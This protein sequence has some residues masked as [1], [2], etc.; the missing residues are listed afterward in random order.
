MTRRANPDHRQATIAATACPLEGTAGPPREP[1]TLWYRQPARE[2]LEALPIGNGSLGGMVYGGVNSEIVQ[3][4]EESLWTGCPIPRDRENGPAVLREARKLLFEKKYGAAQALIQEQF[5]GRRIERGL[6]TYQTLGDLELQFPVR[7]AVED[8]RREL[9]LTTGITSVRYRFGQAVYTREVFC[10]AADGVLV[11][12]LS[13]DRPGMIEFQASLSRD[14]DARIRTSDFHAISLRGQAHALREFVEEHAE[15]S[16]LQGVRYAAR[17][18][19]IPDGGTTN[20]EG[21]CLH[22]KGAD[23]V[24]L[25][26]AGATSYRGGDPDAASELAVARALL[27]P[28]ELLRDDHVAEYRSWFARVELNLGG[29][30]GTR[31]PTDERLER[32]A[33]G[34]TDPQLAALYFQF[35]RY[36]LISSSRPEGLPANLQGIWADGFEPPWNADYHININI[37]MNYWPAEVCNLSECHAPFL[38]FIDALRP[39]GRETARKVFGCRG[40]VAGHTTDVWLHGSIIGR[41][42]YGMWPMGAAWSACHYW[43]HYLFTE[44][45]DFLAEQGY[46][47][48]REAAEFLLDWLVEDPATG[49]LVSGPSTSPENRFQTR[50]GEVANL[51]MGPAMDHQIIRD[52]FQACIQAGSLLDVDTRF[53]ADLVAALERLAPIRIGSDGRLMEWT[54]EFVEP[55]PGHRHVSHLYGLYPGNLITPDGTPELA[56]AARET[57]QYRLAHGGG[58]TGWSRAWITSF[59]ARL[60]D[61]NR[62]EEN[63]RALLAQSTLPNLFDNHPPFQIDGNFGG[64]A[65]I[66]E[67]LL[68]SHTPDGA[69]GW[70]LRLLPALPDAWPKGYVRGLRARGNIEIS[71]R[72]DKGALTEAILLSTRDSCVQIRCGGLQT[73]VRLPAGCPVALGPELQVC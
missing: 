19:L 24:L 50:D 9:D 55:E 17:L 52:L 37:Q 2:W 43:F 28:Y 47:V 68:Q 48:M 27:K 6:H 15:P 53:R 34:E 23:S 29:E 51:V 70:I 12:R 57:L 46:P 60:L 36:L 35:G 65:A 62:A 32:F 49:L 56:K 67:M 38:R 41:P 58:H 25:V 18:H 45:H 14:A 7:K 3:L 4:N 42:E 16:G 10:S 59:F 20:A 22:V 26:L 1:M 5:M 61:G 33:A 39:L 69:G 8:Y 40:F 72:W 71:I 64:C 73:V 11:M 66:A 31:I 21:N 63:L 30:D 54:E 13:C 44:D